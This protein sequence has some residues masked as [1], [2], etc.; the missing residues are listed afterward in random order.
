MV[1]TRDIWNIIHKLLNYGICKCSGSQMRI[2]V[3]LFSM[4]PRSKFG[5]EF[6]TA[7][8]ETFLTAT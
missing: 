7:E 2:G 4:E 5:L 1:G 3:R 8:H 6:V